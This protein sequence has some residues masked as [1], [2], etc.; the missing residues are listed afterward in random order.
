M[1]IVEKSRDTNGVMIK[2][3]FFDLDRLYFAI[4]KF[5]GL[6][7]IEAQ[8]YFDG[9]SEACENLLGLCYEIR[10]A[11]QGDRGIEQVYN[12]IQDEWF[13]DSKGLN[14]CLQED[15]DEDELDIDEEDNDD[16][17]YHSDTFRFFRRNF[18][19]ISSQNAYF[20]IPLSFPEITFYVLILSDLLK[21]KNVFLR[22][23]EDAVEHA[24]ALQALN[25]EY[26]YFNAETDIARIIMLVKQ[27]LRTLY[28][29]IGEDEYFKLIHEFDQHNDFAANC[30]L[31]RINQIITDYGKQEHKQDDP[32]IL[33]NLLT[34][35]FE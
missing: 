6:H 20:S 24:G 9:C 15:V 21:K 1:L 23:V 7:G 14:V 35:F 12:G 13:D 19:D 2:G 4:M 10:H 22:A 31:E 33:T 32:K 34:S 25:K 8:C 5:T 30:N 29:F 11:W 27:V 3:D 26:Y 16:V 17:T 28:V 18:P